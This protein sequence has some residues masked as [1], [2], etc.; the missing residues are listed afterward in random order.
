MSLGH[1]ASIVRNGLVL[2]LDAAN[3]KSYPG[4]G[5][6]WN[7]L[8]GNGRNG[9]LV[10]LPTFDNGSFTFDGAT[11]YVDLGATQFNTASGTISFWV[12]FTNTITSGYTGNQRPFGSNGDFELRWGGDTGDSNRYLSADLGF[13]NTIPNVLYSTTNTWFNTKWYNVSITWVSSSTSSAVYVDGVL[14][15]TGTTAATSTLIALTGTAY[16]ARSASGGYLAGQIPLFQA[17][18]RSL[19][20]TEIQQNFNALRGR[21][22][23]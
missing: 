3:V 5:T 22:G 21:Y 14:E 11:Q 10:N 17:Y 8:S 7:D 20:A 12:K 19:T 1:G 6:T 18:N 9:T 2:Q 23:I 15:R 13:S 4:S 16:I